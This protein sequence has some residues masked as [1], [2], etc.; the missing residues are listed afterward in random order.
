[1]SKDRDLFG[2]SSWVSPAVISAFFSGSDL[3]EPGEI[4]M[5]FNRRD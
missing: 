5:A 4:S 1:M 2:K 3:L